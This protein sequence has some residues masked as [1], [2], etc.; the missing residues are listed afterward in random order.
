MLLTVSLVILYTDA[1]SRPAHYRCWLHNMAVESRHD[2]ILL[3]YNIKQLCQN[4]TC[5]PRG[6]AIYSPSF[7]CRPFQ[8]CQRK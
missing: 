3:A 6:G 4:W 2:L 5:N 8:P 7:V 1:G